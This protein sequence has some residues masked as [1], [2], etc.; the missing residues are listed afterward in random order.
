M[1]PFHPANAAQIS[2]ILVLPETKGIS[3]ERMDA[4][5]GEVDAVAAGEQ[6][7]QA[8]KIEGM[9]YNHAYNAGEKGEAA[10]FSEHETSPSN[11]EA[12]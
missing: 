1:C 11:R 10:T 6:E 4:L 2:V 7:T 9:T 3:L 5:F 12:K 8:E